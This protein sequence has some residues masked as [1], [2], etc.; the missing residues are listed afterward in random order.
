MGGGHTGKRSPLACVLRL[1]VLAKLGGEDRPSGIAD[2][3]A[4]RRAAL[5]TAR[6][7][8]WRRLPHHHTDRPVANPIGELNFGL[9]A[10]RAFI[11]RQTDFHSPNCAGSTIS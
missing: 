5:H 1:I 6:G 11:D 7:L 3:V 8:T 4:H 10:Q 2:G 9:G